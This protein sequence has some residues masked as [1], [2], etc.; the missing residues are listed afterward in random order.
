[1]ELLFH[2]AFPVSIT[3]LIGCGM[4][5]GVLWKGFKNYELYK[6]DSEYFASSMAD[7]NKGAAHVIV[8]IFNQEK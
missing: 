8:K 4:L 5:L 6:D 7:V 2:V 1:M 3:I